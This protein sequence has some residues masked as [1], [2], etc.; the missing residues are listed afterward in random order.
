MSDDG[1]IARAG[2]GAE[3]HECD[4]QGP[5]EA[6][7]KIGVDFDPCPWCGQDAVTYFPRSNA[8]RQ[9]TRGPR[10]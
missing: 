10:P 5:Q 8:A 2:D 7:E 6:V 3:C 4:W 1:N 9:T